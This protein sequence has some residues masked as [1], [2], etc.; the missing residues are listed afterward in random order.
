M[1]AASP[2]S[3]LPWL[4][5][6]LVSRRLV[7]TTRTAAISATTPITPRMIP[8]GERAA[9]GTGIVASGGGPPGG[10]TA[11]GPGVSAPGRIVLPRW[12]AGCGVYAEIGIG[13]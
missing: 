13:V 7:E 9:L 5:T 6:P 8:T 11:I 3:A 12:P 10:S 2:G 1:T 4:E